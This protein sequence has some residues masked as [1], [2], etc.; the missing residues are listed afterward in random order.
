MHEDKFWESFAKGAEVW[1]LVVVILVVSLIVFVVLRI[2]TG[3][4]A[5]RRTR[6]I[7]N[8]GLSDDEPAEDPREDDPNAK[9]H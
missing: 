1:T 5:D 6:R 2:T 8:Q 9:E 3:V 7:L 4:V